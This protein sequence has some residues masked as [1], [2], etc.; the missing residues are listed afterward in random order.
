MPHP[1]R[2]ELTE[3]DPITM[4]RRAMIA[5]L[6]GLHTAAALPNW[7]AHAATTPDLDH[8]ASRGDWRN[9]FSAAV[10]EL[11]ILGSQY[12]THTGA[13]NRHS[14]KESGLWLAAQLHLLAE[15]APLHRRS[16]ALR[17]AAEACA[18]TAGC[19]VDYGDNRAAA[20]LYDRAYLLADGHT[21]LRA[22]VW[23]QWSWVPMYRGEWR[24]V[25]NR[26]DQAIRWA[27]RAGG[28]GLLM[29][30]AHR[31]K[32]C[33]VLGDHNGAREALA[34]LTD[35]LPR[36]PG[37]A[38]PHSALRYS[39]SKAA[40]AASC[41]YAELTDR[42]RQHDFQQQ[43]LEDPSLGWIDRSLLKL[44]H[45]AL[46]PDPEHAAQ[47]IRLQVMAHPADSFNHC[48]KEEAGRLLTR[49]EA[50]TAGRSREI[51][52]TR[53]YLDGIVINPAA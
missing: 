21:D 26:S 5:A 53:T 36:V 13:L 20:R 7:A 48:V 28:Y 27:E 33:A 51:R 47:R 46:D 31:A 43:A 2:P 32:A 45:C 38:L 34:H 14:I 49:L 10:R 16:E 18:F 24:T 37:A 41:T 8:T 35:A 50:R 15:R 42:P 17:A 1:N 52:A 12:V 44:A 30:W 3:V 22:F 39:A 40:F 25:R 19:Y 11:D 4:R 6:L 23:T 9:D 29:G